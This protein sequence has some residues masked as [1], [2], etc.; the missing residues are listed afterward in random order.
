MYWALTAGK[1]PTALAKG[2]SLVSRIDD[3]LI[4]KPKP[5]IELNSRIPPKLNELIMQCVEVDPSDRPANMSFVID[6]LQ[7]VRGMVRAKN[8]GS[9][10]GQPRDPNASTAG[11]IFNAASGM[12]M[13]VGDPGQGRA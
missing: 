10:A 4:P 13:K 9:G 6:R 2:D 12:G 11:M 7:L 1:I 8:E 3:A 5:A